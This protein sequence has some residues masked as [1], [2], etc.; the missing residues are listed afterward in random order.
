M[1][2]QVCDIFCFACHF[3]NINRKRHTLMIVA[4]HT[5][6]CDSPN[7][8]AVQFLRIHH[9]VLFKWVLLVGGHLVSQTC[10]Y[11][12]EIFVF[13]VSTQLSVQK[14]RH[15]CLHQNSNKVVLI[16]H[17]LAYMHGSAHSMIGWLKRFAR[18]KMRTQSSVRLQLQAPPLAQ[19]MSQ[20]R[21]HRSQIRLQRV[22][23]RNQ[24]R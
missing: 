22:L 3:S 10:L 4:L 20:S 16:L 2:I 19:Q 17:L 24:T 14:S 1:G 7:H 5:C 9:L 18:D 21:R 12:Y 23:G 11:K 6:A 8:Q 13:L 15:T